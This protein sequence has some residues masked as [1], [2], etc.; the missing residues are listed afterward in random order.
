MGWALLTEAACSL[1]ELGLHVQLLIPMN[2]V[3]L[4]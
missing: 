4:S 3:F 2:G 1:Q